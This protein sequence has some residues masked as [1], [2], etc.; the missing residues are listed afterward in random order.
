AAPAL[1]SSRSI[2]RDARPDSE[3]S[4]KPPDCSFPPWITMNIDAR[5]RTPET[6]RTG[7]RCR[8]T[9]RPQAANMDSHPFRAFALSVRGRAR[10][11]WRWQAGA[12]ALERAE[13]THQ[14]VEQLEARA[15][16]AFALREQV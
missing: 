11:F 14:F 2:S 16:C 7:Q 15:V 4:M 5:S 10:S 6:A 1:G 8:Y 13:L 12:P 3:V 9:N